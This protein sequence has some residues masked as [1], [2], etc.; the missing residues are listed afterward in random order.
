MIHPTAVVHPDVRLPD[1]VRVGAFS[2]IDADV[3][4]GA[5]CV[6]GPRATL[7][8]GLRMGAR[9]R[10]FP[11]AVLGG[12]PQDVAFS[13]TPSFVEVGDDNVFREGVTVHRGTK[14]GSVTR[15]GSHCYLMA[16]SHVGHNVQ[17]ADRVILGNGCL[18]SGYVEVGERAFCSGNTSIHQFCRIGRLAMVS[19]ACVVSKDVPPFCIMQ[20]GALNTLAGLNVVGLRRAGVSADQRAELKEAYRLLFRAGLNVRQAVT[21]LTSMFPDGP[22]AEL[23]Q[24][25]EQSKRGICSG[26]TSA[27]QSE[28]LQ[29]RSTDP[30]GDRNDL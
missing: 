11:G 6:I 28:S 27:L 15:I 14:E 18:L 7:L 1:S 13:G 29:V 20:T 22:V 5:D 16:N 24:F 12:E 4:V 21:Q 17:L 9:N 26:R 8:S 23:W 3:E 2:I 10:V 25:A 30:S 19:G